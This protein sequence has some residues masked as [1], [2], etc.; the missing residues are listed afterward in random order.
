MAESLEG[1]IDK[2]NEDILN[3]V[4]PEAL[5]KLVVACAKENRQLNDRVGYLERCL[6]PIVEA[7]HQA[8]QEVYTDDPEYAEAHFYADE[9]VFKVINGEAL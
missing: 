7:A 8:G 4:D 9:V 5:K 6:R 1:F 3:L 2:V